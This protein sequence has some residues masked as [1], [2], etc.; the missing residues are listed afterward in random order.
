MAPSC[1]DAGPS[2]AGSDEGAQG[3][4]EE[5]ADAAQS[6]LVVRSFRRDPLNRKAS[7]L[8]EFLL[9][10]YNKK[11]PITQNAL[12]KVISSKYKERFPE[13]L[14]RASERVELHDLVGEQPVSTS[15]VLKAERI[16]DC[17]RRH[18]TLREAETSF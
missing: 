17:D 5:S 8:V 13:I 1:P 2:C 16:P 18:G 14:R 9:E 4:E 12:M 7:M 6:A 10:K 11:E 3:P 15:A